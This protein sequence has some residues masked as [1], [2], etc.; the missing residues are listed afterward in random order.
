MEPNKVKENIVALGSIDI[1]TESIE[2]K[3]SIELKIVIMGIIAI[4]TT[5]LALPA[6]PEITSLLLRSKCTE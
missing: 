4:P 3:I 5:A 1:K 2:N 6:I